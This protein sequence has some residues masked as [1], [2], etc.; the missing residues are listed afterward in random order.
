MGRLR[1]KA[2]ECQNKEYTWLLTEQFI[3]KLNDNGIVDE[4]FKEVDMLEDIE[5]ATSDHILLWVHRVEAQS[6]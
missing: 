5:N 6:V 4:M 3:N 2:A 1:S